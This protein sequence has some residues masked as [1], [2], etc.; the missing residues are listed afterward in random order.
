MSPALT[1]K[2]SAGESELFRSRLVVSFAFVV[3]ASLVLVARMVQL[4]VLEY[5][6]FKTQSDDNRVKIA[7]VPPT[8]GL[9]FDRRGVILAQNTPTYSLE[10]VPEPGRRP[11]RPAR[12]ARDAG[13]NPGSGCVAVPA[14][15]AQEAALR[16]RAAA[17]PAERGRGG[18]PGGQQ[19]PVF[20]ASTC[21]RA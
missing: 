11:G 14:N 6:D 21:R 9:I 16:Q 20:P 7:P 1:I 10:I 18:A 12:G 2:D 17:F 19:P 15:G 13:R 5:E 8:R 3:I 4:Q